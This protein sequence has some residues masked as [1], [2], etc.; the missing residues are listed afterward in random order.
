[1]TIKTAVGAADDEPRKTDFIGTVREETDGEGYY[2]IWVKVGRAVTRGYTGFRSDEQPVVID[3]W[4]CIHSSEDA[5]HGKRVRNEA[6][7]D[8]PIIGAVPN[9]PAHTQRQIEAARKYVKG[10]RD[11][12][13]VAGRLRK[14]AMAPARKITPSLRDKKRGREEGR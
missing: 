8:F 13:E 4:L 3:E 10:P 14:V 1:M 2:A 12:A 9:T 11:Y 5:A 6:V 7:V